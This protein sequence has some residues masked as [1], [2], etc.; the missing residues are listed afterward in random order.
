MRS[1]RRALRDRLGGGSGVGGVAGVEG[2]ADLT[3]I[4]RHVVD[5]LEQIGD[6]ADGLAGEGG[7]NGA[8]GE[9]LFFHGAGFVDAEDEDAG[10]SFGG[11]FPIGGDGAEEH[12][13][14]AETLIVVGD[15]SGLGG[16]ARGNDGE[17]AN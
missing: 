11:V 15:G 5:D 7:D 12:A 9:A 3:L 17:G 2:F 14:P 6:G 16:P 10:L 4:G 13:A 1:D 8:D